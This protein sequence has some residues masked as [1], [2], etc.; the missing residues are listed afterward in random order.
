M[1]SKKYIPSPGGTL[2]NGTIYEQ[3]QVGTSVQYAVKTDKGVEIK[4]FL[5]V[6]EHIVYQPISPSPWFLPSKPIDFGDIETFWAEIKAFVYEHVDLED[7]R[8]YDVYVAWILVSWIPEKFDSVGYLHFHGPRNSGKTRALDV[9]NYV[10]FRPLESPSASGATVFRAMDAYHPTFLLDEFEMYD[11]I[12]ES[13]AEVIGIINSGYRRGQVVLRM[14]GMKEG[15]PTIKGFKVFG[16]K[17][18]SSIEPLPPATSSRCVRFP[19]TRTFRK[20]RRLIDKKKAEEIRSKLLFWRFSH[21]LDEPMTEDNPIDLPDGRLIEMFY[22]L[23]S[24]APTEEIKKIILDCA[25]GQYNVSI[26]EERAT[27]EAQVFHTIVKLLKNYPRLTIPQKEIRE[28][29]GQDYLGGQPMKYQTFGGIM[30]TMGF[31]SEFDSKER[32]TVLI[33]EIAKLESRKNRY[34]LGEE[35]DEVNKVLDQLRRLRVGQQNLTTL[36]QDSA[37]DQQK[38]QLQHTGG[39]GVSVVA[40]QQEGNSSTT[41]QEKTVDNVETVYSVDSVETVVEPTLQER[42]N[43]MLT[44]VREFDNGI[45]EFGIKQ[46]LPWSG[47]EIEKTLKI[48]ERDGAVFMPRLGYWKAAY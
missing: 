10:C 31:K 37:T 36:N 30:K 11:K 46:K 29:H 21:D 14:T 38:Q 45:T 20:I 48:L 19:M 34:V 6:G 33:V 47:E 7:G 32:V 42:M 13:K 27:R 23:E 40:G 16:P 24:V 44:V 35:M 15:V 17:A 41:Q 5:E 26:Q 9:L 3:I 1:S 2:P 12:K 25:M 39:E 8:L 4:P 43:I 28:Q 18:L 22:P